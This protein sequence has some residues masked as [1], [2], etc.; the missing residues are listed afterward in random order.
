M[1]NTSVKKLVKLNLFLLMF[2]SGLFILTQCTQPASSF[3]PPIV[4]NTGN[5]YY[6]RSDYG[7]LI[8]DGNYITCS[9]TGWQQQM[10]YYRHN[11][12]VLGE[13]CKLIPMPDTQ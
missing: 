9:I 3:T 11:L 1:F 7:Y 13:S 2:A 8:L 10:L 5:Y 12:P 4:D 6:S